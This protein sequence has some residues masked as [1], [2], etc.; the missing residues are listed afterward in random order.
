[1]YITTFARLTQSRAISQSIAFSSLSDQWERRKSF[2]FFHFSKLLYTK[3]QFPLP[4]WSKDLAGGESA[5]DGRS[6]SKSTCQVPAWS[7]TA[8]GDRPASGM[9]KFSASVNSDLG[10]GSF[11]LEIPHAEH[12]DR[13]SWDMREFDRINWP[14]T[15]EMFTFL[16]MLAMV[17]SEAV[18]VPTFVLGGLRGST[19]T[20]DLVECV[21]LW[22]L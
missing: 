9:S 6:S 3:L 19:A 10:N 18:S 15:S 12:V 2:T 8:F 14:L 7:L 11:W 5:G 20:S 17:V 16:N 21:S 1:M 4:W 13:C 22:S